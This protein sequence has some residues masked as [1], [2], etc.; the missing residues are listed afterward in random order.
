[1]KFIIEKLGCCLIILKK[2][3]YYCIRAYELTLFNRIGGGTYIS[4]GC[5][6]TP[7]TI[8]IGSNTYIGRNC[9]FQSAHG[10]IIIGDNVMFGAGVHI[11]GGN[12][13]IHTVGKLMNEIEKLPDSDGIVKIANDVWIGSNAIILKGVSINEGAVIGAGSVVTKD[14][15]AYAIAVGNPCKVIKYRFDEEQLKIHKL[16]LNNRL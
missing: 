10:R 9:I 15:P 8:T 11:H 1:M 6:F 13:E 7:K 14:I 2:V 5:H 3:S 16:K 4:P 12:H